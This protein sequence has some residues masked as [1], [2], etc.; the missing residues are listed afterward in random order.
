[1]VTLLTG[2]MAIMKNGPVAKRKKKKGR[3]MND[4]SKQFR[5]DL[6]KLMH[7]HKGSHYGGSLSCVEIII[8]LYD[9]VM[10]KDDVF[11][12]SKGHSCWTL[13]TMLREKGLNPEI[14]HHPKRDPAN[15]IHMTSGSLGHG[16]PFGI[17]VALAKK[18]KGEQG[19]VYVLVGEGDY[20]EG[21]FWESMNILDALYLR[22]V[23]IIDHN[24]IQGS[25]F[26][27]NVFPE[28]NYGKYAGT[29][30]D[31]HNVRSVINA[32][33]DG[34]MVVKA[35]TVKGK[36]VSFMTNKPEWHS[37]VLTEPEYNQALQELQ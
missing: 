13:Y 28:L 6:I 20:Q 23:I 12:L 37:R 9:H 3:K 35:N 7:E 32:V 18:I 22:L 16:I 34:F 5:R 26:T 10:T 11:L 8:A 31:G 15:G 24:H 17:G 25:D 19:R 27:G 14:N 29:E 21:T 4:R 36:G 1:M 2:E 30:I 33:T